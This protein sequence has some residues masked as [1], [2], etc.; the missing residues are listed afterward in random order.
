MASLQML[1]RLRILTGHQLNFAREHEPKQ[2]STMMANLG[3]HVDV[4][5]LA[6]ERHGW[7]L[8]LLRR[9]Q[10]R[11]QDDRD[12]KMTGQ[13]PEG[14]SSVLHLQ[15]A[16]L[17]ASLITARKGYLGVIHYDQLHLSTPEPLCQ[18]GL[19]DSLD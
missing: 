12:M 4:L 9:V 13:G 11:R 6:N 17:D 19:T 7:G 8:P 2:L 16:G 10:L 14:L 18:D 3:G 1:A 5:A 15:I